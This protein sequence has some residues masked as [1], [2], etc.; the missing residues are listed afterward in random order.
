MQAAEAVG[1]RVRWVDFDPATG[2][3]P[4][5][6]VASAINDRTRVVA[7][8][9]ASNLIGTRPDVPEIA[10]LVH[11]VGALVYVDGVHL[12]A[13]AP[14]DVIGSGAD[15]LVCSPYKW[16]G[17][18]CGVL[19]ANPARLAALHPD[20]LLP[21][22]DEVPERFELGT[23]PYETLAGVAAAVDFIAGIGELVG[24]APPAPDRR[25]DILASMAA[26][27]AYEEEL[28]LRLEDGLSRMA[29][30]HLHS[31]AGSRTP[32]LLLSF[33]GRPATEVAAELAD[34]AINAPAGSFYAIEASRRLGLGDAG[35]V[36]VGLAPYNDDEDLDRLLAGVRRAMTMSGK[37]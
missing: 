27:E 14:L 26:V 34:Q 28:R 25:R 23:L 33:D 29:G 22:T 9:G 21:A 30:V 15:F 20:K 5:D 24:A 8:T 17:P 4:L 36:R 16:L 1:A 37:A 18:H 35:G 12:V 13:H 10:R 32:T 11:E 31:R 2:E 3:L 7:V 6:E 19:A